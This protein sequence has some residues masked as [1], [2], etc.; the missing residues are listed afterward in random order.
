MGSA[1]DLV[2]GPPENFGE[3]WSSQF[4]ALKH[5][6]L[7]IGFSP[8]NLTTLPHVKNLMPLGA[9]VPSYSV[10]GVFVNLWEFCGRTIESL[11]ILLKLSI[12]F[13]L[14]RCFRPSEFHHLERI[15]S[16]LW[17]NWRSRAFSLCLF[18]VG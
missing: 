1:S 7:R 11:K 10:L 9:K 13:M 5:G 12:R 4:L 2:E 18:N 6:F 17:Q 16:R 8:R 15:S 3:I 14:F